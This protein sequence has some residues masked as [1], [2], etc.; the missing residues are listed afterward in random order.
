MV[1]RKC[2]CSTA[3]A[4]I[5]IGHMT[6]MSAASVSLSS[7]HRCLIIVFVPLTKQQ[8]FDKLHAI[9]LRCVYKRR[10]CV[11][12]QCILP[13]FSVQLDMTFARGSK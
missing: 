10:R 6:C 1:H 4:C 12:M 3:M 9:V 8:I 13:G 5:D 11:Y 7:K 2:T